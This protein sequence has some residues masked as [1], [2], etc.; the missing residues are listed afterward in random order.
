MSMAPFSVTIYYWEALPVRPS[1]YSYRYTETR[2]YKT[3]R[4][5]ERKLLRAIDKDDWKCIETRHLRK[6]VARILPWRNQHHNETIPELN[7]NAITRLL[8]SGKVQT[9]LREKFA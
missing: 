2:Y 7:W 9:R 4:G 8:G 6:L 1:D 3:S 5:V